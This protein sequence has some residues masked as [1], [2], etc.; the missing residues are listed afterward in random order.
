LVEVARATGLIGGFNMQFTDCIQRRGE[1]AWGMTPSEIG[2]EVLPLHRFHRVAGPQF[3]T[4][5]IKQHRIHLAAP[6]SSNYDRKS[7][8]PFLDKALPCPFG[9]GFLSFARLLSGA[10]KKFKN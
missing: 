6:F 3:E 9:T 5:P 4:Q 1:P 10:T 8:R 7:I 2:A